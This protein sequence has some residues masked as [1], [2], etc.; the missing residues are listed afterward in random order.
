[1][2]NLLYGLLGFLSVSQLAAHFAWKGAFVNGILVDYQL[3]QIGLSEILILI[4]LCLTPGIGNYLRELS[5]I[6]KNNYLL[7][8]IFI[9]GFLV[10]INKGVFLMQWGHVTVALILFFLLLKAKK[11]QW[12]ALIWGLSIAGVI[13][14]GLGL[15]QVAN[16]H[17]LGGLLWFLGERRL[18]LSQAR[19]ASFVTNTGLILRPY[20]SFSH[21]NSLAGFSLIAGLVLWHAKKYGY[22][23]IWMALVVLSGSAGAYLAGLVI[24]LL[25]IGERLN[26]WGKRFDLLVIVG[27]LVLGLSIGIWGK[28]IEREDVSKRIFYIESIEGVRPVNILLGLG[29]G[30]FIEGITQVN[31]LYSL[32]GDKQPVHNI[33]ILFV[34]ENGL[35]LSLLLAYLIYRYR[36]VI[37]KNR[38]MILLIATVVVT[39]SFDHY[40]ITLLQN[41]LILAIGLSYF[42]KQQNYE[43]GDRV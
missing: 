41:R 14:L 15:Y 21:P 30:N 2:M 32:E 20:G 7:I 34:I 39:G 5:R 40:W 38:G 12:K 22:A 23:V 3:I 26:K 24:S 33:F 9:A 43:K 35:I 16:G 29:V 18:T 13:E 19:I 10:T 37:T 8:T 25:S 4:A 27:V 17:N 28:G 1:M 6:V 11:S 36:S 31:H 42:I